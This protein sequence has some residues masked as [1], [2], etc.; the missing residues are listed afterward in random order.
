MQL[1][2]ENNKKA[3]QIWDDIG[4]YL[5]I[6]ITSLINL[7][8]VDSVIIGGGLSNAWELFE[9][10]MNTEIE[11]RALS[12]PRERLTIHPASLGDDAGIIGCAYL[13]FKSL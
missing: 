13:A 4:K 3:L 2:K 1:A 9:K 10:S 6:G 12:G 8:N 5:G 11:K 7:L